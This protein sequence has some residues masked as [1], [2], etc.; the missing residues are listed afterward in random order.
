MTFVPPSLR[1]ELLPVIY[2]KVSILFGT[3]ALS[4]GR[5]FSAPVVCVC[6]RCAQEGLNCMTMH[7]CFPHMKVKWNWS[8]PTLEPL[9]HVALLD[10][11]TISLALLISCCLCAEWQKLWRFG[12]NDMKEAYIAGNSDTEQYLRQKAFPF[13][14]WKCLCVSFLRSASYMRH[15]PLVFH[16]SGAYTL[17]GFQKARLPHAEAAFCT[18][19]HGGRAGISK[20]M[21]IIQTQKGSLRGAM[22]L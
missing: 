14:Y 9:L 1:A 21:L 22:K 13:F 6:W 10:L 4:I 15:F 20:D 16:F 17:K 7:V 2:S 5:R 12:W 8:S 3:L 18:H 19:S 11:I